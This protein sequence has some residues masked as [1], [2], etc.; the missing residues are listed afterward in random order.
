[1]ERRSRATSFRNQNGPS[2]PMALTRSRMAA[3]R[4]R[5]VRGFDRGSHVPDR[6]DGRRILVHDV[7]TCH[8][9]LGNAHQVFRRGWKATDRQMRGVCDAL[10]FV[11]PVRS[12]RSRKWQYRRPG[13]RVQDYTR[14]WSAVAFAASATLQSNRTPYF[15]I[16][17]LLRNPNFAAKSLS[18]M[19]SWPF[20]VW[21]TAINSD[22]ASLGHR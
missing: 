16:P 22:S 11:A 21:T 6:E 12:R 15:T 3:N 18:E 17:G 7:S 19:V 4:C 1:M 10:S 20:S 13:P 14:R 5:Q 8:W 9:R 2:R